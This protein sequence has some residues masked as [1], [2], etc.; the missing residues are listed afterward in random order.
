MQE[1]FNSLFETSSV[2]GCIAVG[3]ACDYFSFL[4]DHLG[5][6]SVAGFSG[7]TRRDPVG[8]EEWKGKAEA[9]LRSSSVF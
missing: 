4:F 9:C 5:V 6:G 2:E 7:Q 8:Q 3:V 1:S